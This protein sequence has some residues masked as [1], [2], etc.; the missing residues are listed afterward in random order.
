MP[1]IVPI[2]MNTLPPKLYRGLL[3]LTSS[4]VGERVNEKSLL[5]KVHS[6]PN[7]TKLPLIW[8]GGPPEM[9]TIISICGKDRNIY[10]LRGTYDFV[11]PTHDVITALSQYYADEIERTIPS[12]TYLIAGYCAAAYISIEVA[13]LLMQR[14]YTIGFLGLVDR[15][16]TEKTKILRIFRKLFDWADRL[17]ARAYSIRDAIKQQDTRFKIIN[18]L[19][20]ISISPNK[21]T[22][23]P[24]NRIKYI[25]KPTEAMYELKPYQGKV[26][27]FFIRWGVFGYYQLGFFRRYWRK[28]AKG[29]LQVEFVPGYSH[30]YPSWPH[31]I[32]MLHNRLD[33]TGY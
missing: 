19:K 31:I 6:V 4:W 11:E 15:D 18:T 13:N 9:G 1:Q 10:G 7:A 30:K 28:I 12:Q 22:E 24:R 27:L 14:G 29:G 32:R 23:D 5:I 25:K 2:S 17:G 16:V 20:A 26:N 8:C 33:E 3:M 21:P